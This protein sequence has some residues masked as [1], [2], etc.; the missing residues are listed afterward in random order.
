VLDVDTRAVLQEDGSVAE[1]LALL[2]GVG[3]MNDVNVSVWEPGDE[4]WRLLSIAE[5]QAVWDRR[6]A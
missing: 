6:R 2:G 3:H 1:T 4:R 5:Q